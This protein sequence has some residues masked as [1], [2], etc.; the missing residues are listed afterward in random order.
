ML[1]RVAELR[2]SQAVRSDQAA[3]ADSLTRR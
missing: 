2:L 3:I 1:E